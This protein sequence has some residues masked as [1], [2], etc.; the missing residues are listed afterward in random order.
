MR[1]RIVWASVGIAVFA[2]LSLLTHRKA[3]S[4]MPPVEA[5]APAVSVA[6]R[7]RNAVVN[8]PEGCSPA[9]SGLAAAYAPGIV[10]ITNAVLKNDTRNKVS[11]S[12]EEFA[13]YKRE[14]NSVNRGGYGGAETKVTFHVVDTDGVSVPGALVLVS[15]NR[16][17]GTAKNKGLTDDDGLFTA[18]GLLLSELIYTVEKEGH[19]QTRQKFSFEG[20]GIISLENGRNIPWNPTLRVTLKAIRK[21]IPMHMKRAKII[22]PAKDMDFEYDFL[23][24]DL[25]EPYGKGKT[26]DIALRFRFDRPRSPD[27]ADFRQELEVKAVREGD[28]FLLKKKDEWSELAS[29]A[30]APLSGYI[31]SINPYYDRTA[32]EIFRQFDVTA[33]D[34]VIFRSRTTSAPDG[35]TVSN[36]GKIYGNIAYGILENDAKEGV[37]M[38]RYYYNPTPNDRSLEFDGKNNLLEPGSSDL[39]WPK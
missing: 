10:V 38:F 34:Y 37:V 13:R 23:A 14:R 24:G 17:L 19:Y 6:Q 18:D 26:A 16:P 27:F 39:S 11:R 9:P 15:L 4:A 22:L 2:V 30:E 7:A 36:Y 33:N 12:S 35:S 3:K 1:R 29:V 32:T 31:P 28:G 20:P 5:R 25:V 21:P 8:K